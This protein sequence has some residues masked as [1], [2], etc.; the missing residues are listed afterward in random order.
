M[1]ANRVERLRA[2]RAKAISEMTELIDAAEVEQRD[3][4]DEETVKYDDLDKF[5]EERAK[6]ISQA[7]KAEQLRPQVSQAEAVEP[8]E[9][10][11]RHARPKD[12]SKSEKT[13]RPD[14][15]RTRSFFADLL[16]V[17]EGDTEARERLTSNA[18]ESLDVLGYD[19]RDMS[20]SLTAGGDF[21]PPLYLADLWVHPNM[22]GRK[23][24]DALPAY[25][26]P[27]KGIS[28]TIPSFDSGVTVA[29]RADNA[30][31]SE[32]DGV[33]STK[34]ASV[35]EYA[36]QVDVGRIEVRRSDPA[37]ESVITRML[38]RRYNVKVDVDLFTGSG[39]NAHKGLDNVVGI[40]TV[41]WTQGTPTGVGILGQ[42]YKAISLIDTN[43]I[44]VEADLIVMN[45][46]RMAWAGQTFSGTSG[47]PIIQQGSLFQ[48]LGTQ[49]MGFT[50]TIAGL[51]VL[52]DNNITASYGAST[53][54]DKIYVL[55]SQDF[56]F[57]EGPLY[58]K[59][60][61]DVGSGTGTI[62]YQV[63]ADSLFLSGRYPTSC[64]VIYGTG[65]VA[66]TFNS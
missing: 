45:G 55:A 37:F 62:R 40:N 41:Q 29:G 44:E 7:E 18:R 16:S 65:L 48:A 42:I 38:V 46:R 54:E 11:A 56:L 23:L 27:P 25:P 20:T 13:Y 32:T 3:L 28:V 5:Q 22:A 15:I 10:E 51:R 66:P 61:E 21:L 9:A 33:T 47:S 57:A 26:L 52:R 36:G 50:E 17:R 63:F 39:T 60:Y 14:T 35:V 31:V 49:D 30:A 4:S 8:V 53:N 1:D 24:A 34:S 43:R 58:A 19:E 6:S 59:V 12:A 2:E 64:S